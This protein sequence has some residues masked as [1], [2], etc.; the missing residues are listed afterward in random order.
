[1]GTSGGDHMAGQ[2]RK[3]KQA[4]S[5]YNR[6]VRRAGAVARPAPIRVRTTVA[7]GGAIDESALR[8]YVSTVLADYHMSLAKFISLGDEG[9]L[10]DEELRDLWLAVGP[11]V[12]DMHDERESSCA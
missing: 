8:E 5:Q 3:T 9:S 11:T 2:R 4:R 1:M 6:A 7:R 12:H 10:S